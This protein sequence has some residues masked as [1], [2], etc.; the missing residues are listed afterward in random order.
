M[1]RWQSGQMQRTVNPP[2]KVY[3]GSN[4]SRRTTENQH[5]TYK[6]YTN[7]IKKNPAKYTILSG[8]FVQSGHEK[9]LQ[10][11]LLAYRQALL[12]AFQYASVVHCSAGRH[13]GLK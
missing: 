10:V 9:L 1:R 7:M 12:A 4:P 3:G 11:T 5:E 8:M 13:Q 6:I 2:T